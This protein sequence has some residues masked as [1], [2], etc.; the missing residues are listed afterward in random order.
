LAGGYDH[1]VLAGLDLKWHVTQD[2]TLDAAVNPDFAQV[3]T[4]QLILNLTNTETFLPEKRPL[5][6]EGADAFATPLQVF[7]SRRIGSAPPS[8]TLHT[9]TLMN[10]TETLLE[11]PSAAT[12]Y[13]AAKL[14]GRVDDKWSVGALAAVT[15]RNDVTV[16]DKATGAKTTRPA[17]PA[18]AFSVLRL[19]R[20]F[21]RNAYVGLITTSTNPLAEPTGDYP[22]DTITVGNKTCPSGVSVVAGSRCFHHAFLGGVDGYWRSEAGDYVAGG[23]LVGT[24]L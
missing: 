5:F 12:I 10:P 23:Q 4:D 1:S 9:D 24:W 21:G 16:Q 13:G 11:V 20:D 15:A 3:E 7:Y 18:M 22:D 17:Q 8:P 19:K 2:L 14:V 6:L